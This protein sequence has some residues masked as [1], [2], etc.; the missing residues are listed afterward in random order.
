MTSESG[1]HGHSSHSSSRSTCVQ[2]ASPLPFHV[3]YRLSLTGFLPTNS[4][5]TI[6]VSPP[7]WLL[8]FL[9][10][11]LSLLLLAR[12]RRPDS[13]LQVWVDTVCHGLTC[14]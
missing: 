14:T 1:M 10:T 5:V 7:H 6:L 12:F 13:G 3:I 2:L 8:S 11:H 9:L 4:A